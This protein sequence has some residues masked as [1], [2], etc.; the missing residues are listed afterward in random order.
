M[1]SM[2]LDYL[3]CLTIPAVRTEWNPVGTHLERTDTQY[4]ILR[5]HP[6]HIPNGHPY[7]LYLFYNL[8]ISYISQHFLIIVSMCLSYLPS[9]IISLA[10][11]VVLHAYQNSIRKTQSLNFLN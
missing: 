2:T 1:S 5:P 9:E 11:F 6:H 7:I 10:S 3:I 4:Q 8:T